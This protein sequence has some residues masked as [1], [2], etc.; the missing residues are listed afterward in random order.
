MHISYLLMCSSRGIDRRVEFCITPRHSC[1]NKHPEDRLEAQR[2]CKVK[3]TR[4]TF[5]KS[6]NINKKYKKN[7]LRRDNAKVVIRALLYLAL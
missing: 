3:K 5:M 6:D 2:A 7:K 1:Y 4:T